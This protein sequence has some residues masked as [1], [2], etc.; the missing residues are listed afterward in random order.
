MTLSSLA[1]ALLTFEIVAV[2]A[3]VGW[4]R[5]GCVKLICEGR[6]LIPDEDRPAPLSGTCTGTTPAVDEDTVKVAVSCP[7]VT[8]VKLTWTLQLPPI[9]SVAPQ[10]LA[11]QE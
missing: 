4:P 11:L 9:A 6:M 3:A 1:D 7:G 10:V 8:G 2:C 5:F